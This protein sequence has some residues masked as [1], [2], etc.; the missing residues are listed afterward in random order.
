MREK[1]LFRISIT[2]LLY[3]SSVSA[4]RFFNPTCFN[5]RLG[6][7]PSPVLFMAM[8]DF[9]LQKLDSMQRT[10]NAVTE[11]LADPDIANDR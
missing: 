7:I 8:D 2:L 3:F 4:F 11:R 1:H 6:R 5:N 9:F 10:F